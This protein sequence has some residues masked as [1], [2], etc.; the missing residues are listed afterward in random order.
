MATKNIKMQISQKWPD[1]TKGSTTLQIN[2]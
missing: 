1:V 2:D